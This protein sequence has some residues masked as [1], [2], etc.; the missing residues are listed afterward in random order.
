MKRLLGIGVLALGLAVVGGR[1]ASAANWLMTYTDASIGWSAALAFSTKD[2]TDTGYSKVQSA[3]GYDVAGSN[4]ISGTVGSDTISGFT[5][6][7]GSYT[8]VALLDPVSG[9][10]LNPGHASY[11]NVLYPTVSR[12]LSG[13]GFD[14][15]AAS[16]YF[17]GS[18]PDYFH[19]YYSTTNALGGVA[20]GWY[21][22]VYFSTLPCGG[23]LN[24]NN[25]AAPGFVGSQSFDLLSGFSIV[26]A[27]EPISVAVFA[28]GLLAAGLVRRR[29]KS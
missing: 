8:G 12:K 15:Y 22:D 11:D 19:V 2:T 25:C 29:R 3:Y 23:P 9:G 17:S 4:A 20:P 21:E 5:V 10:G 7:G 26:P 18:L 28:T 1:T 24:N 14:F 16:G 27:P 13:F 6:T